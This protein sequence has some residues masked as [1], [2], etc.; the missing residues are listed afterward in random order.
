MNTELDRELNNPDN[1]KFSVVYYNPKDKRIIVPKLD[2]WRG[3]TLNFGNI[4]TYLVL[5]LLIIIMTLAA[6]FL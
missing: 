4:Y 6:L 2:K 5:I 1:Y 3:W